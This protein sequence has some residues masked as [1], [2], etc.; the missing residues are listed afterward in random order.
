MTEKSRN[1]GA[2]PIR[3][4]AIAKLRGDTRFLGDLRPEGI[5]YACQVNSPLSHARI[6]S[7][8]YRQAR[9][10][11]GVVCVLG[12]EDVPGENRV[13]VII[14]D[15]ALFAEEKV[16]FRG[17]CMAIVAAESE[18]IAR[19]AAGLVRFQL[20][21]LPG[22]FDL[23]SAM[24]SP[25]HPVHESG[26][27]A[28]HSRVRKGSVARGFADADEVIEEVFET[29]L[30]EHYYLETLACLVYPE[31]DGLLV[32]GSLQCPF[33]VQKA[34]ARSSA[35]PLEKVRVVQ[36]PTGGAFGGKEDVPNE[37]CART[38]LLAQ[39]TGRPVRLLLDREEDILTSSKRHPFRIHA[40]LGATRDG[41][42]TA[43]EIFQ[44]AE[45]GAYATLSPPVIY[46]A[47]M[48][49][50]GPYRI[51]HVHVESRAWYTNQVPNGAFRGFGSPQ[52]CF[53]HERMMDLMAEKL[54]MSP[55]ELR[56]RNLLR[57][58]D[59]TATAH[60]LSESVG[61]L[62]T[63]EQAAA[64]LQE[65]DPPSRRWLH[66][67]GFASMIYGNCLGKAGWHMDGAAALL[68]L[69]ED[70]T[71]NCATGLT[72]FGQGARMVV[73]QMAAEALGLPLESFHLAPTDTALVRDSGPTVASRNVVMSGNAIL[74]AAARLKERLR[75]LA[76]ELLSCDELELRF[77]DGQV[78]SAS[79]SISWEELSREGHRRG[80][81][82]SVEGWWH[83]PELDF[84]LGEGKGEAYFAYSFAT[85]CCRVAV[86][87]LS[88][89][90]KVLGVWAAHDLGRV[91]NRAGAEAQV[92]GGVAQG[93]GF[94]LTEH[95]HRNEGEI[96][97]RNLSSYPLP[98]AVDIPDIQSLLIED[99]HPEGPFG[100]KSLGEPTIIPT[101]A[102]IA[103]AISDAIGEPVNKI[104]VRA[105][106]LLE[107]LKKAGHEENALS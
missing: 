11:E 20:E 91:I 40:R 10:L 41:Q 77:E 98:L 14:D 44:D 19:K 74:D 95:F 24:A 104:P 99:P 61:A 66:G 29:G 26:P 56:R 75:P 53:A 90:V 84:D 68:D 58:G 4:D 54:G 80:L 42:L 97:S 65:N 31:E 28:C 3:E 67:T 22:V 103:N 13:G 9:E 47:A 64:A 2:S 81:E 76:A 21:E 32:T 63:L 62:E 12:A 43:F 45:S 107:L 39:A 85:H 106:D 33:Y 30:Q 93:I 6:L 60:V 50:A 27:I 48:Q 16:R 79:K 96:L 88:G 69:Q 92:E 86:D 8:D 35:L 51:P 15:Q 1:L 105:E 102:A 7:M 100:A 101:A 87:T 94:A 73:L 89:Q 25:E 70:G 83:V 82:L 72:E 37:L 38:A 34:V 49:G 78:S 5:L 36:T 46:R 59:E 18:E 23:D 71:L 55:V 57:K 17:E 52:V